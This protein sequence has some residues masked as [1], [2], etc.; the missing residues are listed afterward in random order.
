M[1]KINVEFDMDANEVAKGYKRGDTIV[2]KSKHVDLSGRKDLDKKGI[3]KNN[4]NKDEAGKVK[5]RTVASLV[6]SDIVSKGYNGNFQKYY[7]AVE[8][9]DEAPIKYDI[10]GGVEEI[11]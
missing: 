10:G 7:E 1:A 4:A 6:V 3:E 2:F 11:R 5:T 8:A 9:G